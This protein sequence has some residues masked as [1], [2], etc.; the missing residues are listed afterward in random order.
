MGCT[1]SGD[2][3]GPLSLAPLPF[4]KL[5]V[6]ERAAGPVQFDLCH[7]AQAVV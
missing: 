4:Q 5:Q 6:L 7:T 1:E 2:R 3:L